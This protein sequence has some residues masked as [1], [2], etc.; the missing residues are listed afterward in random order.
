M[1]RT[2]TSFHS[3][4]RIFLV[5]IPTCQGSELPPSSLIGAVRISPQHV[6]VQVSLPPPV[7]SCQDIITTLL[8]PSGNELSGY[9]H[10]TSGSRSLSP[11]AV[12]ISQEHVRVQNFLSAPGQELSGY[13]HNMYIRVPRHI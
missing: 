3:L 11:G 9:H 5:I 10:N 7:R 2:T 4:D 1:T 12:S 8:R 13:H 6:S